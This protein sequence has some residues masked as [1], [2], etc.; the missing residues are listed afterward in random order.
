[1]KMKFGKYLGHR[2]KD[3]PTDY[4]EWLL[5]KNIDKEMQWEIKCTIAWRNWKR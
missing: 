4:L 3:V 5:T 1:M 2:I